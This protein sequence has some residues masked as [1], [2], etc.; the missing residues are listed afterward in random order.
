MSVLFGAGDLRDRDGFPVDGTTKSQELGGTLMV[1]STGEK[2]FTALP[3]RLPCGSPYVVVFFEEFDERARPKPP[4]LIGKEA[5][6]SDSQKATAAGRHR[7]PVAIN[8][9]ALGWAA[10]VHGVRRIEDTGC[11]RGQTIV[12][13]FMTEEDVI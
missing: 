6:N 12:H 3:Y 5:E 8:T 2:N 11:S 9:S 13:V 1:A 4:A 10:T 7:T